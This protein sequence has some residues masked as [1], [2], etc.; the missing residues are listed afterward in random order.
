MEHFAG[1]KPNGVEMLSGFIQQFER[2]ADDL[3]LAVRCGNEDEVQSIDA[4][5]QTLVSRIFGMHAQNRT[6]MSAQISFFQRLAVKN[7]EDGS[8]VGRY[9]S[10]MMSLFERYMDQDV[11]PEPVIPGPEPAL[12]PEGCD[13]SLSEM[14]LD[15]V[16]ERVAVVGLDYRYIY[17]N[18]NNAEFHRKQPFEFIGKHLLDVIDLDRFQTRVKPRLDQCFSG[19]SV[20]YKYEVEDLSGHMFDVDCK[21]TPLMGP[22]QTVAGAIII[23]AMHPMFARLG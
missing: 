15:S 10:M 4:Q 20:S 3:A 13:P 17:C 22:D 12:M 6:E 16:Q 9:T 18:K 11:K 19:V 1:T 2:I 23:L 14:V 21:L 8:S 5:L 7:C